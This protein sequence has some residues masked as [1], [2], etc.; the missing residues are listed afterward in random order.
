MYGHNRTFIHI[1]QSIF[2]GFISCW[3]TA[4]ALWGMVNECFSFSLFQNRCNR[5]ATPLQST[6]TRRNNGTFPL[7]SSIQV[8]QISLK[9]V[10]VLP[11]PCVCRY[12][13]PPQQQTAFSG[14]FHIRGSDYIHRQ[15]GQNRA[16]I[17]N[18]KEIVIRIPFLL[19]GLAFLDKNGHGRYDYYN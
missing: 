10:W 7:F 16:Y 9:T 14:D 4:T 3:S 1:I 18:R 17:D 11:I 19:K 13:P 2:N 15:Q 6:S 5:P 12:R 8:G